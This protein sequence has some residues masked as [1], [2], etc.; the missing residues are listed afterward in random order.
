MTGATTYSLW[1]CR[2]EESGAETVAISVTELNATS[3]TP[4]APLIPGTY[5]VW[6]RAIGANGLVSSW[7]APIDITI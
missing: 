1:V 2:V 3:F 6:L 7:S 5:R 4:T